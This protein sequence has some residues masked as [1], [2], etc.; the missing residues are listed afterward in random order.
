MGYPERFERQERIEDVVDDEPTVIHRAVDAL[1]RMGCM[2]DERHGGHHDEYAGDD[3]AEDE[4]DGGDGE[5]DDADGP[6]PIRPLFDIEM[7]GR[8]P[9]DESFG[10]HDAILSLKERER[11]VHKGPADG[12]RFELTVP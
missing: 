1:G 8:G 4:A 11:H 5:S 3:L 10:S 9:G 2:D 7:S 12:V 6:V